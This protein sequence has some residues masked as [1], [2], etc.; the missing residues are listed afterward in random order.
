MLI[1]V[2]DGADL[3]K[4]KLRGQSYDGASNMKGCRNGVVKQIQEKV[5]AK[6]TYIHCNGHLVNLA[7]I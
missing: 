6:A 7:T 5:N 3:S 1:R 4:E 2:M